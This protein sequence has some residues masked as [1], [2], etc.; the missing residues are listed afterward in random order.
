MLIEIEDFHQAIDGNDWSPAVQRAQTSLSS[1]NEHGLGATLYFRPR[2]Y[3]FSHSIHLKRGMSLVG[4]GAAPNTGATRLIFPAGVSGIIC[5]FPPTGDSPNDGA[6]SII[7]RLQIIG[8]SRTNTIAHGVVMNARA[9]LRD[10]AILFFSGDGIHIKASHGF[11]PK[12]GSNLWQIYNCDVEQ[13]KGN[14]LYVHGDDSNAGC[15]IALSCED[16]SGWGILD[17]SLLN[18]TYL[19]CHVA[20]G[21]PNAGN[22]AYRAAG[23]ELPR[24]EAQQPPNSPAIRGAGSLFLGC[25][26]EEGMRAEIEAPNAVIGGNLPS[27]VTAVPRGS[28]GMV[29]T[30]HTGTAVFANPVAGGNQQPSQAAQ[31]GKSVNVFG[32]LGSSL[33]QDTALELWVDFQ[34]GDVYRLNYSTKANPSTLNDPPGYFELKFNN[35]TGSILCFSTSDPLCD[36]PA[37]SLWMPVGYYIG[38]PKLAQRVRVTT[39]SAPPTS[40]TAQKGDRILNA[41]PVPGDPVKGF[42]GWICVASGIP[43]TWKGFGLIET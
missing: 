23:G 27:R 1:V 7:E 43:G 39:G 20:N 10:I 12:S 8:D 9:I 19:A 25:Y 26:A 14:G 36:L 33:V 15:A 37:N 34:K 35:Q 24:D 40:G 31:A 13:C 5:E 21:N 2:D 17:E 42:A 6:G 18:N 11:T 29:L 16:N 32:V 3:N 4:S 41:D 30:P 28:M 38:E 22:Q